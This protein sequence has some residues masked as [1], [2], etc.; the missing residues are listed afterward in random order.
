[1]TWG[2][3]KETVRWH[4]TEQRNYVIAWGWAKETMWWHGTQQRKQWHGAKQRKL[5]HDMRL[6]RGPMWWHVDAQRKPYNNIK[7][8]QENSNGMEPKKGNYVMTWNWEKGTL[9]WHRDEQRIF[10]YYCKTHW[11]SFAP[12]SKKITL[13]VQPT[14]NVIH[15][16]NRKICDDRKGGTL[17][18]Q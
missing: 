18:Q 6:K 3:P 9:W 15:S 8:S 4:G 17:F 16:W 11:L 14:S 12:P 5:C 10:L 13:T 1:M 2:W 7:L